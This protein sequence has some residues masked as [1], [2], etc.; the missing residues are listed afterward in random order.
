MKRRYYSGRDPARAQSVADLR[1]M[2][3]RRLPGFVAEYMEGGAEEEGTLR[4]NRAGFARPGLALRVLRDVREVSAEASLLGQAA[5]LPLV[6]APTGYAGIFWPEGD[7]MLAR[8]AI[9]FCQSMI[10]NTSLQDVR[11]RTGCR[12]WMQVYPFGRD[13]FAAVFEA[14]E[15]AGSEAV[16]LTVDGPVIGNRDWD[17]RSYRRPFSLSPRSFAEMLTHPRWIA[18]GPMR[19]L[20]GFPNIE[21][22][23][24]A[25]TKGTAAVARWAVSGLDKSL[26][27]DECARLRSQWRG[28][29]I[30]KGIAHPDDALRAVEAGADAV[31]VSNHGGRQLDG[32]PASIDL[33]PPVVAAVAGRAEV[34]L[35]SGIRRGADIVRAL[36]LCTTGVLAG[37][38]MLYGLAAAGEAGVA[39]AIAIL[40]EEMLRCM[41]LLGVTKLAYLGPHIFHPERA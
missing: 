35:D 33:L 12:H 2:A 11:A 9:P 39:R 27:W 20:P 34:Y 32:A 30:V 28:R 23:A 22:Y 14:A 4:A 17:R 25:G 36:A 15:K 6:I 24:P 21:A 19:G 29:F 16:V 3:L 38:A 31:V 41:A 5:G 13:V 40:R 1:A 8:A 26:D 18:S 10:S 37:R 7:V